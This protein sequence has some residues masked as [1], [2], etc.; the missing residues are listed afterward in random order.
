MVLFVVAFFF[1]QGAKVL[2]PAKNLPGYVFF[3]LVASRVQTFFHDFQDGRYYN[4]VVNCISVLKKNLFTRHRCREEHFF[5]C[6]KS[7]LP[8]EIIPMGFIDADPQKM[9]V[10]KY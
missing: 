5:G 2:S 3:F 7:I 1:R 9:N 10:V 6:D 8:A 4:L